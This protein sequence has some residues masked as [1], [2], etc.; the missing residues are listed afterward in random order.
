MSFGEI[1]CFY[2]KSAKQQL[3]ATSST[4]AEMRALYSLAIDSVFSVHLCEELGRPLELPAIVMVDNQPE[5]D[6]ITVLKSDTACVMSLLTDNRP[7]S[8]GVGDLFGFF[9]SDLLL[10]LEWSSLF[11][12]YFM[13]RVVCAKKLFPQGV[14]SRPSQIT[15]LGISHLGVGAVR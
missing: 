7:D 2:S 6:L 11:F 4:H 9:L 1:G 14:S 5:I 13:V 8:L 12:A 15:R 3:V 10:F